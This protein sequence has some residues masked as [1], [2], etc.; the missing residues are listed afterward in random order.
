VPETSTERD[1]IT[2]AVCYRHPSRETAISCSNCERPICPDCMVYSPVGIKCPDCARQP[3]SAIVRLKP[4]RAA[5]S[6]AVALGLGAAM[7]VGIVFLQAIGLFFALILGWLIGIGMGEAVLAASGRFRGR[8]TGWIAVAGCVWAYLFPY[9]LFYGANV[10]DVANSLSR[11]PFVVLGAGIA[12]YVAYN[13][14]Q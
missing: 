14:T 12:A 6:V 5:R 1:A 2:R 3:R 10:G 4:Q 8:E 9:L 7:G 13:R 11:A